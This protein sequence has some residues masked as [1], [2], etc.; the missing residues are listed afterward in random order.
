M[1]VWHTYYLLNISCSCANYIITHHAVSSYIMLLLLFIVEMRKHGDG[2]LP[3]F[4]FSCTL[5]DTGNFCLHRI[6]GKFRSHSAMDEK[7]ILILRLEVVELASCV[8]ALFCNGSFSW[9]FFLYKLELSS[10]CAALVPSTMF[11]I[12]A[13]RSWRML[14]FSILLSD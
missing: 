12:I 6:R 9:S 2:N 13:V 7:S 3:S 14:M 10:V 8:L 4:F 5:H 1:W 11:K